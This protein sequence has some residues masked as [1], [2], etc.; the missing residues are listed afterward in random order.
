MKGTRPEGSGCAVVRSAPLGEWAHEPRGEERARIRT[1]S[2]NHPR[3]M[4]KRIKGRPP[5]NMVFQFRVLACVS[6]ACHIG[7][8]SGWGGC[9]HS[10]TYSPAVNK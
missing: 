10:S 5:G 3:C 6:R 7:R 1:P 9:T 4:H 8:A 2:S